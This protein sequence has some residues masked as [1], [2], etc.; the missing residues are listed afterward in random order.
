[1][2]WP[3][4]KKPE[5]EEPK[6]PTLTLPAFQSVKACPKCGSSEYSAFRYH[7]PDKQSC[8]CCL[9]A[10]YVWEGHGR[11]Y[12]EHISRRCPACNFYWPER[13]LDWGE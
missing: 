2:R 12:G 1:M 5:P 3:W 7:G 6:R 10:S 9:A 11:F 13:P 4:K 8:S